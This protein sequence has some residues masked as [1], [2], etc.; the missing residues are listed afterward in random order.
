MNEKHIIIK[1]ALDNIF[2]GIK[3]L[4]A[5][6]PNK[7]FTIDGRLVGDLGE[8]IAA[9]NYDIEL[10]PISQPCHDGQCSD[11][12]KVQV[13][14]TFK[15][16]LTFKTV[17]DYYLGLRLFEDGRYEEIYNGPGQI[18]YDRFKHRSGIGEELLSFP[19]LEIQMLS[20]RV[21]PTK[22]IQKRQ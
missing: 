9:L 14:A 19:I 20:K 1:Q 11:G 16:S 4:S 21:S 2:A 15:N 13:K 6:F 8:V 7:K 5:T 18:I 17:P 10:Y 3:A 22:R 12:R